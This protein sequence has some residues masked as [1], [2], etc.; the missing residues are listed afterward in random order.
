MA[1]T[2]RDRVVFVRSGKWVAADLPAFPGAHGQGRTRS[3]AF[4]N[5][6]GA[7]RDLTESY[8]EPAKRRQ[9]A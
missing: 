4:Q 6:L 5:L 3:E 7:L 1:K 8:A 9:T 2:L